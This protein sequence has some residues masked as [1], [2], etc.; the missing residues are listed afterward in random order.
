MLADKIL[1]HLNEVSIMI[2]SILQMRRLR[3]R[4]IKR[5]VQGHTANKEQGQ[6]SN[7]DSPGSRPYIIFPFIA[8]NFYYTRK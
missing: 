6:D 4:E 1:L 3:L 2:S 8:D 7:P 5:L